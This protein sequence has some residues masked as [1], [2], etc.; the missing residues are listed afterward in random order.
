MKRMIL[1]YD[2]GSI[3]EVKIEEKSI[4]KA[5]ID[6]INT[7][8]DIPNY[9]QVRDMIT[10]FL[11]MLSG[12]EKYENKY[13][14]IDKIVTKEKL[15][16]E[17]NFIINNI[18]NISETV[19]REIKV[20]VCITGPYT[21]SQVFMYRYPKLFIELA[22]ALAK[23]TEE[24][25][26]KLKYGHVEIIAL[27]EPSFGLSNDPLI[28]IGTEGREAL[29]KAW[30]KIFRKATSRNVKTVIHLHATSD[31]LFWEVKSLNVIESHV[32]DH[33]YY[34]K[35]T[36]QQLEKYDKFIKASICKTNFD[37]LIK[38]KHGGKLTPQEAAEIWRKIK[39]G[40]ENPEKYLENEEIMIKRLKNIVNIMGEDRVLYAGPE[41]GL[42]GFP[43]YNLAIKYLQKTANAIKTFKK[44]N[45]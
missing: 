17:L 7:G 34:S 32:N 1:S 20:K 3:P 29:L 30:E 22:D 6:K 14:I 18:R 9:P 12:I 35:K 2:V 19:G 8:I 37:E 27:D 33:I 42:Y 13:I 25:I 36:K 44:H 10:M 21:L 5:F 11:Q 16:P 26:F 40:V 43:T 38:D 41:C 31:P 28:D 23:I 4:V 45:S 15:L 39:T 24:N